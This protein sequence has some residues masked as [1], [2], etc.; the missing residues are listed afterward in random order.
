MVVLRSADVAVNSLVIAADWP[1]SVAVLHAEADALH[2]SA[3][4]DVEHVGL[5]DELTRDRVVGRAAGGDDLHAAGVERAVGTLGEVVAPAHV[6]RTAADRVALVREQRQTRRSSRRSP[7]R[8]RSRAGRRTS[9]K[10]SWQ[11]SSDPFTC[12][13]GSTC[14]PAWWISMMNMVRPRC[15]GDVPVGAGEAHRVR[16]RH[17]RGAPDLRAVHHPLVAVAL[18]ACQA[19]GEVGAAGGLGEELHPLLL[20]S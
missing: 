9:S 17:R 18:G 13:I 19:P 7:R 1:T 8:R 2:Q 15:L 14:T 3:L 6:G 11:N 10:N 16:G 5:R 20:A 4:H 12:L